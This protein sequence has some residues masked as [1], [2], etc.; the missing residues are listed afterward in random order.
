MTDQFYI[1]PYGNVQNFSYATDP[2]LCGS[3]TLHCNHMDEAT[4]QAEAENT[5]SSTPGDQL[6]PALR[7][8][9][10]QL[11][12]NANKLLAT[13]QTTKKSHLPRNCLM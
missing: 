7:N 11:H 3:R 4:L 8:S 12:G 5:L 2:S 13:R 1:G 10:A 6:D 9:L